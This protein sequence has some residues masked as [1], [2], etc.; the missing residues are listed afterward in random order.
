MNWNTLAIYHLLTTDHLLE[1]SDCGLMSSTPRGYGR[2]MELG[3]C[4]NGPVSFD[5]YGVKLDK[6]SSTVDDVP[7]EKVI[8]THVYDCRTNLK[9]K[10]SALEGKRDEVIQTLKK[11]G[12]TVECPPWHHCYDLEALHTKQLLQ[13]LDSARRC[14]SGYYDPTENHGPGIPIEA[15]KEELAKRPH[16]PNKRE[17]KLARQL[18]AKR[19]YREKGY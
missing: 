4:G 18:A 5:I 1:G 14:G 7:I 12:F 9:S 19:H 10:D 3:V 2:T 15:I 8:V 11:A 17:A 6:A 16:I 13:Y